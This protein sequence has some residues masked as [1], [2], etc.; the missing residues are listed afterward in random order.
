MISIIAAVAEDMG[1]GSNNEL[2]WHIPGDL[3]RFKNLTTG[4]T[5]IMGKKTW[6][7]LPKRPLAGR[8]NIILSDNPDDFFD[9]SITAVSVEDAISKAGTS[10][11]VFIIGGASVYKQFLPLADRL[12]IS[13]IH[14]TA[15]A[16]VY[17]P[18]IDAAK[19]KV[20]HAEEIISDLP[21]QVSYTYIIYERSAKHCG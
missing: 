21:E 13:H 14:A 19:W 7:S 16:D 6:E 12:Y 10:D 3:R 2:L 15:A 9:G 8:T 4:R 5:V 18:E 20:V 1:L 11:E 17:F